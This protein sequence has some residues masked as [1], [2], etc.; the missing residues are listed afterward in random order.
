MRFAI[1]LSAVSLLLIGMSSVSSAG[2]GGPYLG[3][4]GTEIAFDATGAYGPNAYE[5][6]A[7]PSI[8]W[9]VAKDQAATRTYPG[10][11]G[12]AHLV[13][14]TS[15]EEQDTLEGLFYMQFAWLGGYQEGMDPGA[16]WRWVTGEPWDY[17]NWQPGEPNDD[18]GNTYE[19]VLMVGGAGN[20]YLNTWNDFADIRTLSASIVEYEN[21]S[22]VYDW[23]FGDGT[24]AP[25]AGPTPTHSYSEAGIYD[26]QVTVTNVGG[27][28]TYNTLAVVYDPTGGF[29]TGG[30]W[31][32]SPAG[33]YVADPSLAGKANFGFVSKY[34][35]GA[36][37][38]TGNTEFQF[39]T[40][41][42]NFHSDSY[43]W[44]VISGS[45]HAMFKGV[46]TIN[47][48]SAY[49][50]MLWAGDGTGTDGGDT[51]RLKIWEEDI[52]GVETVIYDNGVDQDIGGG[53]V[54]V[55]AK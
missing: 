53:S 46:G 4:V 5:R 7:T 11:S 14:I 21:C 6:V 13:T 18:G 41:D 43:D 44:L 19:N 10:C 32:D 29:A 28:T 31:I 48:E 34:Q 39:Q 50:F 36:S 25:D 12:P 23:D 51:L 2:T 3:A 27:S 40:A 1:L 52:S 37:V 26:V 20:P 47:G 42:L 8:T 24:Q 33:A 54:V 16:P 38:P 17:T 55:H 22:G 35:K 45:D 49:K 30:G 9:A 15:Q